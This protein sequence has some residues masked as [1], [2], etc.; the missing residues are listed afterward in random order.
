MRYGQKRFIIG[1]LFIPLVLYAIF[2]LLPFASSI[3]VAFTR[4]R[5]VSANITFNGLN[6]LTRL[7]QDDLFW[8]ALKNNFIILLTLPIITVSM[9][10]LFAALFARG[11][12]GQR[13]YRITF[14]FPQVLS[15]AVVAVL[16]GFVY[17][18]T[19]GILSSL[20]G[21][22][23]FKEFATFPWLG[24]ST[25]VLPSIIFVAIWQSVGFYMV[26]F[27]ASMQ[28]IP[29]EFYEAANIDG[30]NEWALF[31]NITLPLMRD[32]LRTGVVF[33]MMGAMDMFA[34][35]SI[36]TNET[37]GPGRAA[38]VL[39]SYLYGEAFRQQNFGYATMLAVVL[40]LL[41]LGLSF[42]GLRAGNQET[43]E[44]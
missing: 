11:L 37:G 13:F 24:E 18:P 2:V 42:I 20:L 23:G 15:A 28:S 7:V 17:H 22:L 12:R 41:V 31:W 38:Q 44:F 40:M 3:L 39:S 6:N 19:I 1:F 43:I 29:T 30:A 21:A 35:V 5:G 8:N 27:I 34:Y 32:T 26:L 4:W 25:T 14:F 9:G 16:F 10:L 36:L 33:L